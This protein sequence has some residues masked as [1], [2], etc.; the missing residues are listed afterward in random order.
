[1]STIDR[2]GSIHSLSTVNNNDINICYY[3]LN[4]FIKK[5]NINLQEN[6]NDNI[7][8]SISQKNMYDNISENEFDDDIEDENNF[9]LHQHIKDLINKQE[10]YSLNSNFIK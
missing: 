1:L 7:E 9:Y 3:N 4:N 5:G 6:M 2:Y 10:Y 8:L